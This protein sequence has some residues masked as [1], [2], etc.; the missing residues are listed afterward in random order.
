MFS[1]ILIT[2][3]MIASVAVT[4]SAQAGGDAARGADLSVDCADCHGE[5][6][7]GD[8]DFP[9][10]AGLEVAYLLE[11]L[12]LIKTGEASEYAIEMMEWVFEDL[13][14]QDLEDIAAY[15]ASLEAE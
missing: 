11:Q 10:L 5:D 1:R 2:T 6:G 15:Y 4:V 14:E 12:T 3:L 13:E 9:R 7:M 8:D